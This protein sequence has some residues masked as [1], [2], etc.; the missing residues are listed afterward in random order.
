MNKIAL[1]FF[2]FNIACCFSQQN[3]PKDQNVF[4]NQSSVKIDQLWRTEDSLLFSM[5]KVFTEFS[6]AIQNEISFLSDK[7]S[8]LSKFIGAMN[9]T[10]VDNRNLS[11]FSLNDVSRIVDLISSYASLD[12]YRHQIE[13]VQKELLLSLIHISEPTRPY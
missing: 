10:Q 5:K 3:L 1:V 6:E 12:G 8:N 2:S 13:L 9:E 11:G 7:K 4:L